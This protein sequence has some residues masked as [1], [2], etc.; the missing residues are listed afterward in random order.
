M[1]VVMIFLGSSSDIMAAEEDSI[2]T[3]RTA[4]YVMTGDSLLNSDAEENKWNLLIESIIAIESGGNPKARNPKGDCCGIL[5]ITPILVKEVNRICRQKRLNKQYTLKDRYNVAK[6]KEMFGIIQDTYNKVHD[7]GKAIRIW[8]GGP[9]YS[10]KKTQKY[11]NKVMNV[12]NKKL[13][14]SI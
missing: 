4:E 10:T 1:T 14:T 9:Y 5:Q 8:N 12:F 11:Y 3:C 2:N 6:S 7:I 13:K